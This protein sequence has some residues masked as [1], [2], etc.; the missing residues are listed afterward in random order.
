MLTFRKAMRDPEK[1]KLWVTEH[2][3]SVK[4]WSGFGVAIVLIFMFLSDRDF[5]FLLTMSS[6]VSAFCF[7][8]VAH[9]IER[10]GTC[11]G[12]SVRMFECYL[13]LILARLFSIIPFEGYLPYDRTGDWLYQ[14]TEAVSLCLCGSIVYLCRRRYRNTY[15]ENADG[16][17]HLFL[18]VPALLL[19]IVFHPSLNA[20]MPADISWTFALYLEAI[21]SLPQLFL[22]QK[23]KKVE[24]F[25]SHF[26]A[27]QAFSKLMS[28]IFW[29]STHRELN[30]PTRTMK[31]YVGVWVVVMQIVQLIVMG[32]FV[33]HYVRCLS[34]GVPVQFFLNENV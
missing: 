4:A 25:T 3:T 24:P 31:S 9:K 15:N 5:S 23:E 10:T 19:A 18:I 6:L 16:L 26:L 27:G 29:I 17:N 20:F 13:I 2:K 12:I 28:F 32:D 14:T 7:F 33:Y 30:D 21:A 22:F 1:M 11:E 8:M 34:R